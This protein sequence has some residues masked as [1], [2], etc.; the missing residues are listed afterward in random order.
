MLLKTAKKLRDPKKE[1]GLKINFF[2]FDGRPCTICSI[3]T[4]FFLEFYASSNSYSIQ[5]QQS[6]YFFYF[7]NQYQVGPMAL[8]NN[9][10]SLNSL[11]QAAWYWNFFSF[12][13]G[14]Q[15]WYFKSYQ[16][17]NLKVQGAPA[18]PR[19]APGVEKGRDSSLQEGASHT[20]TFRLVQSIFLKKKKRLG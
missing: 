2:V 10:N 13:V 3:Y 12:C 17:K 7:F 4:F 5:R 1:T 15:R 14:G 9:M 8:L 6:C 20:Y 18:P 11:L 19:F 16:L